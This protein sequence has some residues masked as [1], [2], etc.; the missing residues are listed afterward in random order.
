M[1]AFN[2]TSSQRNLDLINADRTLLKVN[3]RRTSREYEHGE[4]DRDHNASLNILERGLVGLGRPIEPV[5]ITPLLAVPASL[6]VEAGSPN[7]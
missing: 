6:I 7:P 4:L 3:P 1:Y 5:E 2:L